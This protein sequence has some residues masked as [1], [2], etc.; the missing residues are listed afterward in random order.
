MMVVGKGVEPLHPFGYQILSLARLPIPPPDDNYYVSGT[1]LG[2]VPVNLLKYNI[3]TMEPKS[4]NSNS[5]IREYAEYLD[6]STSLA[7][8]IKPAPRTSGT[9][10]YQ[11]AAA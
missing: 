9:N 7:W 5:S 3:D 1:F 8:Q 4:N 6:N 2:I 10:L 11:G